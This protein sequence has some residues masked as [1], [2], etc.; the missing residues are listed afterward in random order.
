MILGIATFPT[1]LLGPILVVILSLGAYSFRGLWEDIV[2]TFVFGLIGYVFRRYHFTL[3]A[4]M[5]GLFL[6][7]QIDEDF[8]RFV[9]L[10]GDDPSALLTKPIAMI[11]TVLSIG[12]VLWQ[13]RK[14]ISERQA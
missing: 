11:F 2:I 14:A 4:L 12:L 6:G 1:R 7:R 5:V 3:I 8:V 13:I 9:I 10:Y